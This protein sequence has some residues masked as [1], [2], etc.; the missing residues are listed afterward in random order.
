MPLNCSES[1]IQS[2]VEAVV[3]ANSLDGVSAIVEQTHDKDE[4]QGDNCVHTLSLARAIKARGNRCVSSGLVLVGDADILSPIDAARMLANEAG[5]HF[6]VIE[7]AGHAA[8]M[9]QPL[10][11][12][13]TALAFLNR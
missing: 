1:K 11:W 3:V 7:G 10:E 4:R 13:R 5:W 8:P 12:R 6:D 2:F 9:E